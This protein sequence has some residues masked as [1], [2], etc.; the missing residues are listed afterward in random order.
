M[1]VSFRWQ[2]NEDAEGW[3]EGREGWREGGRKKKKK[4][5]KKNNDG[6]IVWPY[7]AMDA[8]LCGLATTTT[9]TTTTVSSIPGVYV[10]KQLTTQI[11]NGR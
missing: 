4:K 10:H 5:K 6:R 9:T 8:E 3:T 11:T 2:C 1:E 7:L